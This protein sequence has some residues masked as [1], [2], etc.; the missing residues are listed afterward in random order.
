MAKTK[1]K[2]SHDAW[3]ERKK[4]RNESRQKQVYIEKTC[5]WWPRQSLREERTPLGD[6]V[7]KML[8]HA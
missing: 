4:E 3:L 7:L 2:S 5:Q 1:N 6:R 8:G